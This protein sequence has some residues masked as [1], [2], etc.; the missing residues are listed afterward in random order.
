M[1]TDFWL[2][3]QFV[4]T[5]APAGLLLLD[6]LRQNAH[7]M[8]T[9]EGCKEGDC[10]ACVVL[11]GVLKGG[12]I[13]YAPVTSCVVP[14]GELQGRHVVSIEGL[15]LAGLSPV[16]Q[17]MVDFGGSQ[18]GYCTPGFIVSMTW[19]LMAERGAP[20]LDGMQRAIS[21]NLCRCTG[22]ASINRASEQLI[23]RFG[24]GGAWED[25][26]QQADRVTALADAG[27]LPAYFSQMPARLSDLAAPV[28]ADSAE[29]PTRYFVA[30]GTDLYVQQGEKIPGAPVQIL[31]HFGG[32]SGGAFKDMRGIRPLGD[33]LHVGALTT[34]EEFGA[35][36]H[37]QAFILRIQ[38]YLHLI[39]SLH[40]RN[41]ATLGGNI[42]NAS[43]I[44]DMTNLLLALGSKL[45]LGNGLSERTVAMKDFFLGYKTLDRKADE[46]IIEI[47][48]PDAARPAAD[49]LTR[50][51]VHFEK[52]S[53][54]TALDI[55]TVCS[56]FRCRLD[57]SGLIAEV[58]ISMGGVAAIPLFLQKTCDA[59]V[60][61]P[62]SADT[63]QAAARIAMSEA[64]P[65]GDIRGSADYKRLLVRQFLLAHF[66]E[67]FPERVQFA[68]VA[69]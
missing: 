17:A 25:V 57:A 5:D 27:M 33:D 48:I 37:V 39:A 44:G 41:R 12:A 36:A 23:A 53:K 30:G 28:A 40:I 19:Y 60:G 1:T 13:Q 14:L 61:K 24:A 50:T 54:R 62:V 18:C 47:I 20:T 34:F 68:Q 65:I 10:G 29:D 64:T 59:L 6:F 56:G 69:G 45:R 4:S 16:Q 51:H 46:L 66:I 58:G 9:K 3:D 21:G 35:D 26:W 52:L 7:L 31:N 42:V 55:A 43:P 15:N 8:G 63:L 67:A 32:A 22:Y 2:N 11:V 38:E 49:P